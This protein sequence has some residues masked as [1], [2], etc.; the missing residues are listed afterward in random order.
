MKGLEKKVP[1]KNRELSWLDFNYR[2]LEEAFKVN[3]PLA[4][5]LN[6]LGISASN[7]DEFFMVR[8]AGVMNE[9]IKN[10]KKPDYSGFTPKQLLSKTTS[11][12]KEFLKRQYVC[13]EEEIKNSLKKEGI[14]FASNLKKLTQKQKKETLDNYE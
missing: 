9:S 12:I 5:K 11:K 7:L 6:F 10:N 13:F 8:V 14:I 1:Y 3:T 4:E 2:V